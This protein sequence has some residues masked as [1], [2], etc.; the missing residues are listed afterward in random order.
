M[1]TDFLL[2]IVFVL[3][4]CSGVI[5]MTYGYK[6]GF[7]ASYQIRGEIE[8]ESESKD[9]GLFVPKKKDPAEFELLDLDEDKGE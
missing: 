9:K 7:K 2:L 8:P 3:G 6:F 5:I 4:L 1:W